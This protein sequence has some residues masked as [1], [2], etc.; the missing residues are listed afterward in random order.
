MK[1][2]RHRLHRD[3]GSPYPFRMSPNKGGQVDHR[4]LVMHYTAGS[5][6]AGAINTLIKPASKASA[7]LVI[8]RSGEITQ[9]VPFD[10]IAWHAGKSRWHAL[11]GLNKFSIGIELDNAGR[12][13]RHD[14]NWRAWFGTLYDARDVLE[15]THKHDSQPR[16]WHLY[17]EPQLLA[18]IDVGRFLVHHYGLRDVVG[19]DDIAPGR[20]RDPGPAFPMDS[21][22]A[23]VIG[24]QEEEFELFETAT[25]LNIRRGPGTQFEKLDASPLDPGTRLKLHTRDGSWCSVD[26]LEGDGGAVETGWV[27]GDFIRPV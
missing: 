15:A 13:E 11:E 2:L 22:R 9:L 12:L 21:F 23:A 14:G 26:V 4:Y 20:K 5:S 19:H 17:T 10:R 7:H 24:R 1:I 6:A 16:G 25:S 27:H 18:A 8:A 3:D